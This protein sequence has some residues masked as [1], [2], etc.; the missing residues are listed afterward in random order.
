MFQTIA[1]VNCRLQRRS[2]SPIVLVKSPLILGL[3]ILLAGAV[4]AS[5]APVSLRMLTQNN[6][7]PGLPVLV[8][9]EGYAPDGSRDKETW[10]IDA[11]LTADAGV[12]LSTNKITLR[13]GVG[14]ILVTFTGGGN[15]NLTATVGG[16]AVTRP[17]LT[18]AGTPATKVG[19]T[20]SGGSGTW[21]GLIN[22]TSDVIVTNY[23]LTIQSNTMVVINGLGSGTTGA[24]IIVNANGS[25]QSLGTE[26]HPVTITCSNVFFTN[27]WGRI[28]HN[29]SLPSLYRHTFIHRSGRAP[30]EGHTGQAAAIRTSG[31]TLDFQSST[32]SD[33]CETDSASPAFGTPA[34]VMFAVNSALTFNDCLFQRVR[35]GPEIDGTSLLY[36]N[37]YL[38]E[39]RGPDDSDGLYVHA[40]QGGQTVKITDCVFARGDDDGIDTLGPVMTIENCL[41]RE[42]NNLLEDAKGISVF[43]GITDV[44]HCL[45]T[46]CTVA[47]AAKTT[48]SVRVNIN[49]STFMGN[50]TNVLAAYKANA[51]GPNVE[52][53]I[54]N[55]I[56][57]GGNPVHSDFEPLSSNSTNFIIRYCDIGETWT[58]TG[59]LNSDPLFVNAAAKNLRVQAG[60]PVI[61]AG[62]PASPLDA[63]GT[64]ADVGYFP[65]LTNPNPLIAL[66]SN[67]RYLD[68]GTDQ[69]TNWQ[70]R[71][72]ND[73]SWASGPAQ[74]GYGDGDE[75]TIVSFGPDSANKYITTYFRQAFTVLNPSE[76]T[77]VEARLLV[78][79]GAVVYLNG[80]EV[81]RANLPAGAISAATTALTAAEPYLLL[82]LTQW[83]AARSHWP[84][85]VPVGVRLD[86]GFDVED[87]AADLPRLALVVLHF[88]KWVDGRAY[89][90]ARLLRSRYRFEGE[91]R[92]TGD[93][94]V[95]MLPLLE[96]TGFD[97]A[98]LRAD[99]SLDAAYR[100]LR[101][102]RGHYQGDAR[103]NRPR[104]AHP[105]GTAQSLAY[106][107]AEDFVNEGASI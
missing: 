100:A 19:G 61:N 40:Q 60:S 29:S 10:D 48:S 86:N 57:W 28:T 24:G 26:Q 67:W 88:P 52:L 9:V 38:I 68:N 6:Y 14:S 58:G 97:A 81:M 66:G 46:D 77:N 80:Q 78:D 98:V 31:S 53:R 25:I 87:V 83:R 51:P 22:V 50:L 3:A 89:S 64:L 75:A 101:F 76:F 94:L 33:L 15:F 2:L 37:S 42:W 62:N 96:R 63:D 17:L 34:K 8:R 106:S 69:G 5:A 82:E 105:P 73:S 13:N 47:L 71:L 44:R 41:F 43:D 93:V 79:D 30:G 36:T 27:R 7:L 4:C 70:A 104:F 54:T 85:G 92:A 20:L 1:Q 45:F 21:S 55:S 32:I 16:V 49:N 107:A 35:T 39:A 18:L 65:F 11:T 72:F 23:T 56:I 95:D 59:N 12:S 102:F 84:S 90:Q 74:L 91:I 103:D 99:Q